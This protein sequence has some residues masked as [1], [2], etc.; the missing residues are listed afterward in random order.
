MPKFIQFLVMVLLSPSALALPKNAT[1]KNCSDILATQRPPIDYAISD[2]EGL[3]LDLL[4]KVQFS[5]DMPP[6]RYEY[7]ITEI[8]HMKAQVLNRTMQLMPL[9]MRITDRQKKVRILASVYHIIDSLGVSPEIYGLKL[10]EQNRLVIP[11]L[12]S[13]REPANLPELPSRPIGFVTSSREPARD[14]LEGIKRSIGFTPHTVRDNEDP[15]RYGGFLKRGSLRQNK[16]ILIVA[17]GETKAV[18]HVDLRILTSA[19]AQ[20]GGK[21]LELIFNSEIA[22]W[23]VEVKNLDNPTGKIGFY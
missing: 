6:D 4:K 5:V 2:Y 7:L 17:D 10:N 18:Y 11:L 16:N 20:F 13:L 12:P 9:F 3:F 23:M 22:E 19:G 1:T 21:T 15:K 8:L 14:L